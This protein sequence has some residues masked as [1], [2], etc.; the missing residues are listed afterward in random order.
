MSVDTKKILTMYEMLS[1]REQQLIS[2]LIERLLPDDIATAEDLVDI[3]QSQIDYEL[4]ETL[5]HNEINWN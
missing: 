5:S 2:E 3:A 1:E 4:G